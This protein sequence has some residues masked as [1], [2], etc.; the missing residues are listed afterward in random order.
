[1]ALAV[2]RAVFSMARR[3]D[4]SLQPAPAWTSAESSS[5]TPPHALGEAIEVPRVRARGR[6]RGRVRVRVRVRGRGR[7]TVRVRGAVLHIREM[8]G[9][10][11]GDLREISRCRSSAAGL[12]RSSWARARSRRRAPRRSR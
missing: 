8:Y 1:V 10:S 3:M 5:T 2:T 6:A 4:A 11:T 9:R 12:A 7:I